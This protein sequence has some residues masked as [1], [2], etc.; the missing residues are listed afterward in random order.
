MKHNNNIFGGETYRGNAI[1]TMSPATKTA[2]VLTVI[3]VIA[4]LF[5]IA[6]LGEITARIA[7]F[8][9]DV[10]TSGFLI[11]AVVLVLIWM[12]TSFRYRRR[13]R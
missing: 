4:A 9:A 6:N 12:V 8:V 2:L 3:S 11:L 5:I 10:L 7:I 1:R 13:Y